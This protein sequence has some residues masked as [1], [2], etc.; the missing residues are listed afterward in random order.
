MLKRRFPTNHQSRHRDSIAFQDPCAMHR[1]G[2]ALVDGKIGVRSGRR[3]ASPSTQA[4]S[5]A[6][7]SGP[8]SVADAMAMCQCLR[9]DAGRT[10]LLSELLLSELL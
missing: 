8:V 1:P 4:G 7:G 3:A 10:V 6:S 9:P 2:V 5:V